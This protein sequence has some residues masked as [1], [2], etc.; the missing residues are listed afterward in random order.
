[1]GLKN[2]SLFKPIEHTEVFHIRKPNNK[3]FL[4]EDEDEKYIYVG[5]DLVSFETID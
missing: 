3:N 1:M 4:F 2:L 5:E